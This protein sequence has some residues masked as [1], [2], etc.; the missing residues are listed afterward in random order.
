MSD[1][2]TEK[3]ESA[4][5]AEAWDAPQKSALAQAEIDRMTDDIIEALKS[6]FD[7]EIPVDIYEL[8]LIYK[9]DLSDDRD[10]VVEMTL[11]AGLPR[12]RRDADLGR[13]GGKEGRGRPLGEGGADLR[14]AV[15]RLEDERRGQ[16]GPEHVLMDRPMT[17]LQTTPVRVARAPPSSPSP[18]RRPNG[19][20][21]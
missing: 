12:G 20:A 21:P 19:C 18:R 2:T 5:F 8:G 16:A 9:V 17:E 7:P 1:P 4:A 3:T 10:V 11:T 6:V 15:G 14:P 13:G